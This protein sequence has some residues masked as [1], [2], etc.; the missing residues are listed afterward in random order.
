MNTQKFNVE[1]TF[2]PRPILSLFF[3]VVIAVL[4]NILFFKEEHFLPSAIKLSLILA[5]SGVFTFYFHKLI[6]NRYV[7]EIEFLEGYFQY[8][9]MKFQYVDIGNI[10]F[11]DNVLEI[12]MKHYKKPI[13]LVFLFEEDADKVAMILKDFI[14]S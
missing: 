1:K 3:F 4:G 5:A 2:L 8:K 13:L 9:D 11:Q 14:R 10:K 6:K 12:Y 7:D